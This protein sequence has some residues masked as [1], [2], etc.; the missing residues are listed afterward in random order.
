VQALT[1]PGTV[2]L[3][4]GY[5]AAGGHTLPP[6]P[7]PVQLL[8]ASAAPLADGQALTVAGEGA[9]D[10]TVVAVAD[11]HVEVSTGFR[12]PG[13]TRAQYIAAAAAGA[14]GAGAEQ[15]RS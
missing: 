5:S 9:A 8:P 6:P 13:W 7:P 1:G 15:P 4:L 10:T 2:G 3:P 12:R 11:S 14:V